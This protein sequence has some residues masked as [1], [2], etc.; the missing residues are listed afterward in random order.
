MPV[1]YHLL[2][3]LS[4][5]HKLY[6]C[7]MG[8]NS[9]YILGYRKNHIL[10]CRSGLTTSVNLGHRGLRLFS[11]GRRVE[12]PRLIEAAR[13]A[14]RAC[15]GPFGDRAGHGRDQRR[16]RDATVRAGERRDRPQGAVEGR[17]RERWGR[18]KEDNNRGKEC[19]SLRGAVLEEGGAGDL[20]S[21]KPPPL[22]FLI[23]STPLGVGLGHI[24]SPRRVEQFPTVL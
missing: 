23:P 21:Y 12:R 16:E 6:A 13:E 19:L 18:G 14:L 1:G 8:A 5:Y 17:F 9:C 4:F 2:H 15:E 7:Q 11:A 3:I 22:S 24:D 10:W 20:R